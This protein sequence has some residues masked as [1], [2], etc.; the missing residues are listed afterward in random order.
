MCIRDRYA[1]KWGKLNQACC[2]APAQPIS[3]DRLR[4]PAAAHTGGRPH[5]A[6]WVLL[7]VPLRDEADR[8]AALL[9]D[10]AAPVVDYE[11]GRA[12]RTG[13]AAHGGTGINSLPE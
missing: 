6:S 8:L 10:F 7:A 1:Q 5:G 2:P 3:I 12:R 13:R 11:V 9:H 4:R